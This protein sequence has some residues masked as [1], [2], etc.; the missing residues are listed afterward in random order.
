MTFY[1]FKSHTFRKTLTCYILILIIPITVFCYFLMQKTM[2]DNEKRLMDIYSDDTQRIKDAVDS[3]LIE[4]RNI[5]DKLHLNKWVARLTSETDIFDDEFSITRKIEI[6]EDLNNYMAFS[7]ILSNIAVIFPYKNIVVSQNGW[8]SMK[9]YFKSI[10]VNEQDYINYIYP[11]ILNY[12][13]F[14]I[15]GDISENFHNNFAGNS[16]DSN[17][18]NNV[19]VVQSLEICEKPRAVLL[20]SMSKSYFSSYIKHITG[21]GLETLNIA[22]GDLNIFNWQ[23]E[24]QNNTI[25]HQSKVNYLNFTAVSNVC[26]WEYKCIYKNNYVPFQAKQLLPLLFICVLSLFIGTLAA[27]ILSVKTYKPLYK[28]FNKVFK[29]DE[30]SKTKEPK[31][32]FLHEYKLIE[33][34]FDKLVTEKEAIL[35]RV[36]NYENAARWNLL[37]RLLK[38]YFEDDKLV[39][40]LLELGINYNND[41]SYCVVLINEEKMPMYKKINKGG[42]VGKK[43]YIDGIASM[44]KQKRLNLLV[45]TAG[46]LDSADLEYQLLE[47][48]DNDI[49]V[50]ISLVHTGKDEVYIQKVIQNIQL[51][52]EASNDLKPIIT[53]GNIEKGIIGISKSYQVARK[54]IECAIFGVD[55]LGN[56]K[57]VTEG[58]FYYYPTDWE[59]QLI[60]NLKVG[61]FDTVTRIIDEIK[62][63]NENRQLSSDSMKRL[64]SLLMETIIRVLNEL[65]IN[66]RIYQREFKELIVSEDMVSIWSYIYEVGNRICERNKYANDSENVDMGETLLQYVNDNY[67]DSNLSL[68]ELSEIFSMPVSSISKFFKDV[69]GINFYDYICRLRMEKAKGLL[70]D[71][72]YDICNIASAV[73]YENEYSF[74]RAFLRYEGVKPKD[75]MLKVVQN[76]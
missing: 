71:I 8:Y 55:I 70:K 28:L 5:G 31:M 16:N 29:Q 3:K 37:L 43:E 64:I 58:N 51:Q 49:A 62:L 45:T 76:N 63:E 35:R 72:G 18:P 75:Y 7:G 36:K 44:E 39:E 27:A 32:Q 68:K 50:I 73:G 21:P 47:V 38:G 2:N 10:I 13:Y 46:V 9:D 23:F 14:K 30:F 6:R 34:S 40:R 74:K 67:S 1:F 24:E 41:I 60:N 42:Q 61:N 65:N 33:T 12:N 66:V 53:M 57:V 15:I 48:L 17:S 11:D 59:I 19:F 20:L 25:R 56:P 54:N 26:S 4:I 52:I 22:D 69:S